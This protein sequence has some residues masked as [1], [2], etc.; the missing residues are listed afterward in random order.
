MRHE[1]AKYLYD[2]QGAAA[3]V[4]EFTGGCDFARYA[5]DA[6]RRSAVE[7]Q[8][9]IIGE[10]LAQLARRDPALAAR[11]SEH[12]RII[13]FRN[14]LIQGSAEVDSRIV[15]DVV[16]TKLGTLRAE[17]QALLMELGP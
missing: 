5:A 14:T 7:R 9:E 13:A 4:I 6:L 17:V 15:W 2:A 8:L 10:A 12:A 3:R 11:I 16:T 1:S